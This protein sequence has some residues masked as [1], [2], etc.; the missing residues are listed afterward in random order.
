MAFDKRYIKNFDWPLLLTVFLIA[1]AGLLN[2][3]SATNGNEGG[4][5]TRQSIWFGISLLVMLPIVVIDYRVLDRLSYWIY[6]VVIGSLVAVL[7]F[8]RLSLGARRWIDIAGISVQPSEYANIALIIALAM[9]FQTVWRT[10]GYTAKELFI[11]VTMTLLPF[12]LIARQ[13]DLGSAGFLVL[14]AT[15]LILILKVERR[16][17]V[18][19]TLIA[20]PI[21]FLAWKFFLHDY[22]KQRILTLLDPQSDPLGKGYHIIQSIIAVG[23]G[24]MTGKGYLQGSQSQLNFL[25]EQHTDFIFSVLAEE[26]GFLGGVATMGLFALLLYLSIQVALQAKDRFGQLIA[27]GISIMFFWQVFINLAMVIGIFPVV[28]VPL[29]FISYGGSALLMNMAAVGLLLNINMRRFMF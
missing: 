27:T 18:T 25:P 9:Y 24:S 8:G 19:L 23:S 17:L 3:Y 12:F 22:Q 16:L 2:I 26:W 14:I 10:H 4:Y 6:G 20:A 21:P 15:C 13:P 11:P 1:A 28:G 29:P 5:F 7:L